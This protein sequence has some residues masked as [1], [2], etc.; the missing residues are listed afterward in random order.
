P[1]R[2]S[3]PRSPGTPTRA[4]PSR[5]R[6]SPGC[7]RRPGRAARSWRVLP[8]EQALDEARELLAADRLLEERVGERAL[9]PRLERL[10]LVGGQKDDGELARA[11]DVAPADAARE[12]D[13][14]HLGHVDV[15]DHEVDVRGLQDLERARRAL[16][17]D[18]LVLAAHE[19][20]LEDLAHG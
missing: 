12:R 19:V 18:E 6:R 3:T 17:L 16:G 14:V 9:A 15:G 20:H 4:P 13:A 5:T 10:G 11:R 8:L 7:R 2:R 1:R